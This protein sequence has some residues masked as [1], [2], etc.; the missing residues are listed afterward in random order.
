MRGKEMQQSKHTKSDCCSDVGYYDA[1][2]GL[3]GPSGLKE[4]EKKKIT[5]QLNI[6]Y[7]Y[8]N[9]QNP[10]TEESFAG[11]LLER[12]ERLMKRKDY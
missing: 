2:R 3:G 9:K 10:S 5:T 8:I 1:L 7:K 11:S 12:S 6:S 4:E